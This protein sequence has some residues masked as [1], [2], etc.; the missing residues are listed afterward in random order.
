MNLKRRARSAATPRSPWI[1]SARPVLAWKMLGVG[2]RSMGVGAYVLATKY[3]DG[4]PCDHFFVGFV[5]GYTH[6]GRYLC[7]DNDGIA[8]RGNGFRRAERITADEGRQLV[9]MMPVI[10][11]KPGPSVWWQLWKIRGEAAT[12]L[13]EQQT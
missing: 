3:G 11:D 2:I 1:R 8:Q 5:S 6:H 12:G 4:D 7:V 10:G 13:V 9:E